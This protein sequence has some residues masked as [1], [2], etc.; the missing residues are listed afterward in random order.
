MIDYDRIVYL[1][2]DTLVVKPIDEMFE[3]GDVCASPRDAFFNAGVLVLSPRAELFDDLVS[4]RTQLTSYNGGE[5][6]FLNNYFNRYGGS[7][8]FT[9]KA[10]AP[11]A[12]TGDCRGKY[13]SGKPVLVS[14]FVLFLCFSVRTCIA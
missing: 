8:Q 14:L 5:Q 1:D 7:V 10:T 3:C 9:P 6:G 2:A 12:D 11:L 4:K 13:A